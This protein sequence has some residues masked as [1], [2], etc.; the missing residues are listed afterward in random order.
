[1]ARKNE[2]T[3]RQSRI[4]GAPPKRA[5]APGNEI[6]SAY[7]TAMRFS[8]LNRVH[9]ARDFERIKNNSMK[10]DCSAFVFYVL[11]TPE[12]SYSRIAVVASKRVGNAVERNTARRRIRAIFRE[13]APNF[14]V[15]CDILIFVRK[16][17]F[18]FEYAALRKRFA[19]A[20]ERLVK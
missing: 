1:M 2:N 20:A 3:R 9:L 18:K 16:A 19:A 7:P 15:P 13:C 11:P 8:R 17:V 6:N 5:Q 4:G 12:K 10:A 14:A